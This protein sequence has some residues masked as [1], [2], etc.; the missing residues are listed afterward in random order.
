MRRIKKTILNL[1]FLIFA[2]NG[3]AQ[4][5]KWA[6]NVGTGIMLIN[7][8]PVALSLD[9]NGNA[10]QIT[11][12]TDSIKVGTKAF[13][14]KKTVTGFA[15]VKLD[16]LGKCKW[17]NSIYCAK[18]GALFIS[19]VKVINNNKILVYGNFRNT[20]DI[21]YVKLSP[22]DSIIST[23]TITGFVTGFV[24]I[25]DSTGKYINCIKLFEGIGYSNLS[26]G[27]NFNGQLDMDK[28][29]N[30]Y[31]SFSKGADTGSI[32]YKGGS[33]GLRPTKNNQCNSKI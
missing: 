15:L 12:F 22:T 27:H 11:R 13:Y 20:K 23:D 32:L 1:A 28:Q 2:L 19:D 31:I 5:H 4:F 10:Y 16:S 30:I 7:P 3:H 33:I 24:F 26:N 6:E 8:A 25:Y 9:T 21:K 17:I 18:N 29:K 14:S